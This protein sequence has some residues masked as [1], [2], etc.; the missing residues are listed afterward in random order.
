MSD[1]KD[2]R[3]DNMEEGDEGIIQGMVGRDTWRY[4]WARA[5]AKAWQDE[6]FKQ[7]L[8]S[9]SKSALKD[10]GFE[11]PPGLII[12]IKEYEGS[13]HYDMERGKNGWAHM[14]N[15]LAGEVTVILPPRPDDDKQALALADYSAT[16]IAYPFTT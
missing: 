16:G 8:L 5:I 2:R 11:T 4:A 10:F 15:E 7:H 12:K 6:K 14:K 3:P 9:D 1:Y 13:G